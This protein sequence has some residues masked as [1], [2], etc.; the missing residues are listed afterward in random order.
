MEASRSTLR[1]EAMRAREAHRG[2]YLVEGSIRL[3][4]SNLGERGRSLEDEEAEK[5]A[6]NSL[7]EPKAVADA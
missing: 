3:R 1:S 2:S 6:P 7:K 5:G 4:H